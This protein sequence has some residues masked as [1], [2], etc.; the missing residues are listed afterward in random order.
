[1]ETISL[2]YI[3]HCRGL[4]IKNDHLKHEM[5]TKNCRKLSS[6]VLLSTKETANC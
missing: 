1:M 3:I 5:K 2:S 6:D 4:G